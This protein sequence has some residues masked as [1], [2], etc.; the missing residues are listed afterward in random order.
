MR[1]IAQMHAVHIAVDRAKCERSHDL[2]G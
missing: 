2:S 1:T